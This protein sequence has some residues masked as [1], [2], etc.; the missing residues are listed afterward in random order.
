LE[1]LFRVLEGI[2]VDSVLFTTV[3][4]TNERRKREH[5]VAG[6]VYDMQANPT[7]V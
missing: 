6:P 5:Y 3:R 1:V 4:V 2:T 7:V